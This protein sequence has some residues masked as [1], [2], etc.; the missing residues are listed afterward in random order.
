MAA[1]DFPSA[2]ALGQEYTL[3]GVLFTWN[4]ESW[5]FNKF[6]GPP[7]PKPIVQ[8]KRT[9]INN[10]SP[11]TLEPGELAVEMNTPTRLWV[12]VP[13]AILPAKKKLLFDSSIPVFVDAPSDT[14]TYGRKDG[15]WNEALPITGGA[16]SGPIELPADPTVAPQA[17]NKHYVDNAIAAAIAALPP[18]PTAVA[19]VLGQ[20][21][22][23][24]AGANVVLRPRNGDKIT[25][26]GSPCSIPAAGVA[27]APTG[28]TPLTRYY[29]Y[30]VA[31]AGVVT[32]LEA[33]A[34]TH[35][36]DTATAGNLGVEI[37]TGDPTR[38]LVGQVRVIAGPAFVDTVTQRLVR[39]WFNRRN[40]GMQG[41]TN[42]FN[43]TST[44]FTEP[45]GGSYVEFVAW[46][47]E[48]VHITVSG[49]QGNTG[50]TA[51]TSY[52]ICYIDGTGIGTQSGIGRTIVSNSIPV[53]AAAVA[54]SLVEGYHWAHFATMN[55]VAS[56]TAA[57]NLSVSA[58]LGV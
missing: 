53:S 46:Q 35:A 33:S 25:I 6:I 57:Y 48:A 31:T 9:D 58:M 36:T 32:S 13:D 11:A 14:K 7:V 1:F 18:I 28:L 10:H 41:P 54:E 55:N 47:N 19:V 24:K 8:I 20:C 3:N 51:F 2:P 39:S 34:T 15:A 40:M 29:I 12:G 4:G 26:N 30:A 52:V 56:K 50:D 27:L 5:V 37:K 43:A 42:G 44:V 21:I 23:E 38:T 45:S 16:V 49:T 17:A 22:L